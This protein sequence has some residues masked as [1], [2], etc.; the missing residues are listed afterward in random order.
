MV[1]R[2]PQF[3]LLAHGF[4][5]RL[6]GRYRQHAFRLVSKFWLPLEEK[7]RT[8]QTYLPDLSLSH[9]LLERLPFWLPLPFSVRRQA[10]RRERIALMATGERRLLEIL[11]HLS[12]T[13]SSIS[14]T[15]E[16]TPRSSI[17]DARTSSCRSIQ[18]RI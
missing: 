11:R 4:S 5:S 12:W 14:S 1:S 7:I 3:T 18:R 13:V 9:R 2:E 17:A 6:T 8:S 16:A 15:Q 10:S